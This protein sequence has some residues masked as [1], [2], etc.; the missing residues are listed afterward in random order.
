MLPPRLQCYSTVALVSLDIQGVYWGWVWRGWLGQERQC[1][2]II[3]WHFCWGGI[4]TYD[5][6]WVELLGLVEDLSGSGKLFECCVNVIVHLQNLFIDC[7][8]FWTVVRSLRK[9][10]AR[11]RIIWFV[12][13]RVRTGRRPDICVVICRNLLVRPLNF[14]ALYTHINFLT[15]DI[16]TITETYVLIGIAFRWIK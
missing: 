11:L 8:K 7:L 10:V 2:A 14:L 5:I 12:F 9:F 3:S 4:C 16:A 13:I 1:Y 15:K 6:H